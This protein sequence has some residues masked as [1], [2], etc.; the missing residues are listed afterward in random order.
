M[1]CIICILPPASGKIFPVP[2]R[3]MG[4]QGTTN[5]RA[6]F[7]RRF[8]SAAAPKAKNKKI[9]QMKKQTPLRAPDF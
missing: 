9:A 5:R 6:D 3:R 7:R 4:G 1:F 8:R 2:Q